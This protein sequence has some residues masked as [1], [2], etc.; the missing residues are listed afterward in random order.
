MVETYRHEI[1]SR[2]VSFILPL[3]FLLLSLIRFSFFPY[4]EILT[5]I[6]F[7][8]QGMLPYQQINDQHFPGMMLLPLNLSTLGISSVDG[9]RIFHLVLVI[10]NFLI[11]NKL[12]RYFSN[13]IRLIGLSL[14]AIFFITW[15][16]HI[17]WID[18]VVATLSLIGFYLLHT[19][20]KSYLLTG[21]VFGLILLFKQPGILLCGIAAIWILTTKPKVK[22]FLVFVI[23]GV[24]PMGLASMYLYSIGVWNDFWFWTVVHN[25]T[26][27][28]FLEGRQP[29]LS[30]QIRLMILWIP[31]LL[32]AT[33]I[34]QDWLYGLYI[35]AASIFL[36]P[37]FGLIHAQV[38]LPILVFLI[39]Q[40]LANN[41]KFIVLG[42]ILVVMGLGLWY[43]SARRESAG[44][45]YFYDS[46]IQATLDF[47]ETTADKNKSIYVFGVNDNIYHLTQTLPPT[48]HWVEL[49][50][51][52]ISYSVEDFLI[53][54]LKNDPP[55]FIL[56]DPLA[57][58]DGILVRNFAPRVWDYIITN[59]Q[60]N[61]NLANGINVWYPKNETN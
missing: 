20:S 31:G 54:T 56:V 34:K 60:I 35:L 53:K 4:P 8:N 23:G 51:G 7:R 41:S 16:G 48:K 6:Y 9:L 33:R 32:A 43:R 58:Q 10:I 3:T 17:L 28:T 30:E 14:F 26:G 40:W 39:T 24:L 27:Y 18:S 52:N 42:L 21:L 1:V 50:R 5:E 25:L 15:E 13:P 38:V 11:L 59:Y 29:L 19:R 12:T 37:R 57:I 55:Q 45:V 47:V 2:I 61:L 22:S 46:S 36:F 44:K 49:L